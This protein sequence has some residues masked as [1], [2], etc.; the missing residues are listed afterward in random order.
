[1]ENE[2][3]YRTSDGYLAAYLEYKGFGPLAIEFNNGWGS[4]VFSDSKELQAVTSEFFSYQGSIPP[5]VYI[6]E[7]RNAV[8]SL[9]EAKRRAKNDGT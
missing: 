9:N 1:M 4:F 6:V 5:R 2:G 8:R 7:Y 3:K